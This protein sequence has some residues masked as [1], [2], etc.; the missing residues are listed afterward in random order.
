VNHSKPIRVMIVD[1]H[2][3]VRFG[4]AALLRTQTEMSVVAEARSG[5]EAI[6]FF[7]EHL[8]D[9][10][11]MDL[12]MP[13]M[14]GVEAI[15]AIRKDR[16]ESR[17]IVLT[18]YDGD[19]DIHRALTAGARAYLLKGMSHTELLEAIRN[20]HGGLRWLPGP[21]LQTLAGR[22]PN[23]KLSAREL[24]VVGLIVKG[25]SNREIATT[26]GITEG[27]VKWHVN[28][29]LERFGVHDR[30]QAAIAAVRRGIVEL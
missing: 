3:V 15:Q 26:L 9:I 13:E 28:I 30:T 19:E 5:R 25:M 22:P 12:R 10:T 29:I 27:T 16:P 14:S 20:V 18:T 11:L 24:Q 7:G 6:Q 8:P 21:V 17:F 1:D 4:L 2:P 23:C